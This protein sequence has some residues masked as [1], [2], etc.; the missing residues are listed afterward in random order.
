[1]I[2]ESKQHMALILE[3]CHPQKCEGKVVSTVDHAGY[4]S[5]SAGSQSSFLPTPHHLDSST[6]SQ[7]KYDDIIKKM[8]TMHDNSKNRASPSGLQFVI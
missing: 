5:K 4:K 7:A 8:D 2:F 6:N 3:A 1:M